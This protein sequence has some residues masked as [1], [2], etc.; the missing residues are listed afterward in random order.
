MADITPIIPSDRQ[1]IDGY[2]DGQFCVS[3]QWR[4]GAVVVLPDRTEPWRP[5]DFAALTAEDFAPVIGAEPRV[6]FLLLGSGARMQL[7]P[8]A[9]RQ[10]LRDAG[11]VVEVMDTGAAC[12]TYNV[13]LA[14]GR[15]VGAALLPV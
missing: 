12:R 7:L 15:R 11:L 6:E 1:V 4:T 9:L 8:K 2:G 3:G 14:E 5:Q 13:L 10:S